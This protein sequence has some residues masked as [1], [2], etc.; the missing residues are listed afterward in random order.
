M[1]PCP[2]QARRPNR[3][4]VTGAPNPPDPAHL[5]DLVSGEEFLAPLE[6]LLSATMAVS[7]GTGGIV[8]FLHPRTGKPALVAHSG[9]L[10]L[11]GPSE[12]LLNDL[13]AECTDECGAGVAGV[14]LC[15]RLLPAMPGT[16]A[17]GAYVT[18]LEFRGERCGVLALFF[19]PGQELPPSIAPLL[20]ALGEVLGLA[21]ESTRRAH[22]NSLRM[23]NHLCATLMQ[24]RQLLANE[25][26]DSLAQNLACMRMRA[27]LLRDALQQENSDRAEKYVGEIEDSLSVA[28]GRV[29]EL[30]TQ[31]RT[32]MDPE[33]LLHALRT[34]ISGMDG[35]GG[36]E[37]A[38]DNQLPDLKLPA[39]QEMQIL[40]IVREALAN[41][42][43][44]ARARHGRVT[45]SRN[46]GRYEILVE[47]DGVGLAGPGEGG[48]SD[49]GHYGLNIMRER[50]QRLGGDVHIES[51]RDQGTRL[52]LQFPATTRRK[53]ART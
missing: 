30:I 4:R 44:H 45:L 36:V 13:C 29:R 24:E 16:P 9:K 52:L 42:V 20:G 28:H 37:L 1:E 25:V 17:L 15:S 10:S 22:E 53:E 18:G 43:K 49:H 12:A 32:A 33:G 7:G 47:D 27:T 40:H 34:E 46:D 35:L 8:C 5:A 21:L 23:Q 51:S 41:V 11:T 31:F 48:D 39:E 50:A 3:S 14:C 6:R 38:F 19:A 26:H 2:G